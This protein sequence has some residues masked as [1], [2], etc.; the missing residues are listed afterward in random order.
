MNEQDVKDLQ[1]HI[2]FSGFQEDFTKEIKALLKKDRPQSSIKTEKTM[3]N[4]DHLAVTLNFGKSE[5]TNKHYLNNYHVKMTKENGEVMEQ[6]FYRN[7]GSSISLKEAYNL[8]NG[9]AVY[10]T[11]LMGQGE[12]PYNAWLQMDFTKADKNGNYK[13]HKFHDNYGFDLEAKL[14]ERGYTQMNV[15]GDEN[16]FVNAIKK[17]DIVL[18][19]RQENGQEIKEYVEAN[20]R[21]KDLKVYDLNFKRQSLQKKESENIETGQKVDSKAQ[22]AKQNETAS[23]STRRSSAKVNKEG[24][25]TQGTAARRGPRKTA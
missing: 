2:K 1:E 15:T 16:Y 23:T 9:R 11:N 13:Y 6:T 8:M 7:F 3:E 10:K 14:T 22:G 5:K 19:T 4:H 21:F 25:K 12:K 18:A 20:P 17:G 24:A